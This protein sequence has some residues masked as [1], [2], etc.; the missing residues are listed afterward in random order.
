[1]EQTQGPEV[2]AFLPIVGQEVRR[3]LAKG[4][5]PRIERDDLTSAAH[6]AL[7]ETHRRRPDCGPG[8]LR[9]AIRWAL[10]DVVRDGRQRANLHA[11]MPVEPTTPAITPDV[12]GELVFD[13]APRQ[14]TAIRLVYYEGLTQ[15]E[16]ARQMGTVQ[17]DVC[18][19]IG[20]SLRILKK[21]LSGPTDNS[22]QKT[23]LGE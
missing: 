8:A 4:I 6:V 14:M 20:A 9:S 5:P 1:M 12:V 22:G 17:S 16:A 13:L 15:A 7:V 18:E 19:L 23:P 10:M 3:I 21:K 2:C 11:E